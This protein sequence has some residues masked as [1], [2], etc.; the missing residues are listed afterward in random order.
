MGDGEEQSISAHVIKPIFVIALQTY[1]HFPSPL[2]KRRGKF[3]VKRKHK[4]VVTEV[5]RKENYVV[6]IALEPWLNAGPCM[7]MTCVKFNFK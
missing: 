7:S 4:H 6:W 2:L 1:I 3:Q 5:L